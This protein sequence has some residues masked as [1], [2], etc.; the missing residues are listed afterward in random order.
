MNKQKYYFQQDSLILE[1]QSIKMGL[2]KIF[3][4]PEDFEIVKNF[5]WVIDG[6]GYVTTQKSFNGKRHSYKIHRIIM[7]CPPEKSIDHINHNPL[8]NRKSNLRICTQQQN[9]MNQKVQKIKKYSQ[10][11]GVTWDKSRQ[12]WCAK[13]KLNQKTINLG[14]FISEIEA[15]KKYNDSA[16]K[17]FGEFCFLNS[18]GGLA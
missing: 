4:D 7:D 6:H 3:L 16:K 15:A 9:L 1:I 14:R 17:M 10:Y 12:K 2:L 11:K 8:D 18:I 13:I 5:H